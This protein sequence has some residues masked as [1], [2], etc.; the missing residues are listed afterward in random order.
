MRRRQWWWLAHVGI[1]GVLSRIWL[2]SSHCPSG[3]GHAA[4]F[5]SPQQTWIPVSSRLTP[6]AAPRRP[7][8]VSSLPEEKHH[9]SIPNL[10]MRL[11]DHGTL[12]DPVFC[13]RN[14]DGRQ[15][16]YLKD[17]I[18]RA[19][20]RSGLAMPSPD[21]RRKTRKRI[22]RSDGLRA[23][24][25]ES[26][27]DRLLER[28]RALSPACPL[29]VAEGVPGERWENT[30]VV[31]RTPRDKPIKRHRDRGSKGHLLFIYNLGLTSENTVWPD[32]KEAALE[33]ESGD[34]VVFNGVTDHAVSGAI[35]GTS[36]FP[37]DPWIGNRRAGVLVRQRE[38][39]NPPG[40][41][42][43]EVLARRNDK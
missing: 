17:E 32:G 15:G 20:A 29:L 34:L 35:E 6:S 41:I 39:W 18:C 1:I 5:R 12:N 28:L 9:E 7:T 14:V 11:E 37:D 33:L 22:A 2:S 26:F 42:Y 19:M 24:S 30:E 31:V 36:P 43:P 38:L 40:G 8:C 3:F 10:D 27:T 13:I 21:G 4:L 25:I 16:A 23:P